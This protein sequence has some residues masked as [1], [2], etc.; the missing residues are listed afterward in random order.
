MPY[1]CCDCGGVRL[2]HGHVGQVEQV[3]HLWLRLDV[4]HAHHV[5]VGRRWTDEP[6]VA[7]A[8]LELT[9]RRLAERGQVDTVHLREGETGGMNRLTAAAVLS[10]KHPLG[11]DFVV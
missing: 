10:P 3:L 11:R 7:D 2:V 9:H 8:A 1:L 6:R 5:V 4:M